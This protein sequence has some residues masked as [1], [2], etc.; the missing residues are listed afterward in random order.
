MFHTNDLFVSWVTMA[1][2]TIP[3]DHRG[4]QEVIIDASIPPV[5]IDELISSLR[6]TGKES[7]RHWMDLDHVLVQLMES[8]AVH[9]KV[10]YYSDVTEEGS[11]HVLELLPG[12][13]KRGGTE[14][15]FY[16]W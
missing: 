14:E 4:L 2:K 8:R 13:T 10:T 11:T 9:V 1:L 16:W 6:Q 3:T 7:Y 15:Y 5:P 12:T